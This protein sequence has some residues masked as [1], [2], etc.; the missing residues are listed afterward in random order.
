MS[1]D[2]G[3]RRRDADD[4]GDGPRGAP[5][6]PPAGGA[7]EETSPRPGGLAERLRLMVLTR[8]DPACGRPLPEVVD[9]CLEAGATA[10]QLR[11]KG[12][13]GGRLHREALALRPVVRRHGALFLVDDRV[14][15]AL[16]A[17]ADGVHVGPEDPPVAAVRRVAPDGFVVGFSAD[18]PEEG[19]RAAADGAD[20]LGV[21]AVYGTESK[22]GLADEAV[23]PER[24]RE[25]LAAAGL[26]GVGIGG[27]TPGN[28]A[29]V[30]RAGAGVATLGAVMG[31]DDPGEV[32]RAFLAARQRAA[33]AGD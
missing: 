14:D 20:Y 28:A 6:G 18:D 26:P 8:P 17:G 25:V 23:G 29:A 10:V 13:E 9:A 3:P 31:A 21:G 4:A 33:S 30:Y 15:V 32:V 2:D 1:P 5:G 11:H 19:S 24:V 7:G 12:V 16:A 22:E 27:L